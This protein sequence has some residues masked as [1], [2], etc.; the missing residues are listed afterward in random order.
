MEKNF[1]KNSL[2]ADI[3]LLIVAILWGAGFIAVKDSLDFI[4]PFYQMA[5]RFTLST[6]IMYII[7]HKRVNKVTRVQLKNGFIIGIFLFL[8]FALQTVGIKYT[9]AGKS[10]FLT[11]VYVVLVPFLQWML[12]KKKPDNYSLIGAVICIIGISMLT[13]Q[14]G[15]S[16]GYGDTLT[17]LCAFGFAGQILTISKFVKDD[18]PIIL[19]VVQMGTAAL[20]SISTAIFFEPFPTSMNLQGI[21]S[22]IYLAIFS[23]TIAFLIQNV[24]QKYTSST[25]TAIILSLESLFGALFSVLLLN[26]IFTFSMLV[27][28]VFILVAIIIT[29]TKLSFLRKSS[30]KEKKNISL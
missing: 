26:E 9:S 8:G 18:D 24:A 2:Y 15:V 22:I 5:M 30:T 23:T 20:L 19:T 28:C 29:E 25:H 7:F 27:G 3:A 16:I 10:A 6:I 11:A 1:K 12:S 21:G 14:D 4:T 17:L 13:L